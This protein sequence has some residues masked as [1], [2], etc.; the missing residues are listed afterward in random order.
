MRHTGSVEARY[1]KP[2]LDEQRRALA[3]L[4]RIWPEIIGENVNAN[5]WQVKACESTAKNSVDSTVDRGDDD[6]SLTRSPPTKIEPT[7]AAPGRVPEPLD[8]VRTTYEVRAAPKGGRVGSELGERKARAG[9]AVGSP[10]V[11][12]PGMPITRSK[13]AIDRTALAALHETIAALLREGAGDET[14]NERAG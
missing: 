11:S 5:S 6:A 4:P 1:Y 14:G 9:G 7:A 12:D 2:T 3:L 13:I 8:R 10:M